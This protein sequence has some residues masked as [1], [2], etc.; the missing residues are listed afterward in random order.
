MALTQ[1]ELP[2]IPLSGGCTTHIEEPWFARGPGHQ[3]RKP[4]AFAEYTQVSCTPSER[5]QR[6]CLKTL[7][8]NLKMATDATKA[9]YIWV[10]T[11]TEAM[12]KV[13]IWA[14]PDRIVFA[15]LYIKLLIDA[16]QVPSRGRSFVRGR[17]SA[18]DVRR[19]KTRTYD[20]SEFVVGTRRKSRRPEQ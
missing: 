6:T 2:D 11:S 12:E 17:G 4:P 20:L 3:G 8:G 16:C 7:C 5:G 14:H 9:H 1:T 13:E 10:D 19:T 18:R 15:T